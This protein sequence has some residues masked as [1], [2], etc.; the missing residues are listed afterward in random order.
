MNQ[1]YARSSRAVSGSSLVNAALLTAIAAILVLDFNGYRWLMPVDEGQWLFYSDQLLN[2]RVLY[3]DVWYQFGPA[4]LYGL[5]G[6]M[7]LAGKTLATERV[8]FWLMNVAG[9]ASL[10]AFSTVLNKQLTPRLVLCLVALLN[11]LTCRLVMTNPGFLLRQCFNLLPLFLLFKSETGTTKGTKWVF[12][13]G[14]LS[15][16]CV[17]VSQETGLFSFVSGSVFLVS[18]GR[19]AG[20]TRNWLERLTRIIREEVSLLN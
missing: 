2:G 16:L 11:S 7:L 1:G 12:S 6:T 4:V 15:M 9:L 17:L 20:E 19:G 8:F 5:T 13:A 14:V 10:Y 18:R 3:K